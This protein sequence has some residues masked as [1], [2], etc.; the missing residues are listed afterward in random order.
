M[1]RPNGPPRANASRPPFVTAIRS[2][3]ASP[4][5]TDFE[6]KTDAM[7][8][9]IMNLHRQLLVLVAGVLLASCGD[10]DGDRYEKLDR[11]RLLAIRSEPADLAVGETATLSANV[12]EPAGRELSYE[13]SWCPS[14]GDS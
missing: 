1:T 2:R 9:K 12:Y 4:T 8:T 7:C 13:W 5:R 11:L 3:S 14:R 6:S 10:A